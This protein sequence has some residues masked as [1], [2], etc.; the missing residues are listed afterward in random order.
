MSYRIEVVHNLFSKVHHGDGD[1]FYNIDGG[2][3]TF[4]LSEEKQIDA[5]VIRLQ[6]EYDSQ[7]Y[8]RK[9]KVEYDA[10]NQF[11]LMTDDATNSTTTHADAIAAIKTKYPK[12]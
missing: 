7:E 9:R 12:G 5:E 4:S 8:S 11:E 10:L 3:I 6:T 1:K 2:E